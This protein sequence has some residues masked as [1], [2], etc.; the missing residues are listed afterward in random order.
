MSTAATAMPLT[1]DTAATRRLHRKEPVPW[2]AGP[3]GHS[4]VGG[5][6]RQAKHPDDPAAILR[7]CEAPQNQQNTGAAAAENAELAL[8]QLQLSQKSLLGFVLVETPGVFNFPFLVQF[9]CFFLFNLVR[10]NVSGD[11]CSFP[12][13]FRFVLFILFILF[14]LFMLYAPRGIAIN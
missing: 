1:K 9:L 5:P 13:D 4:Q 6:T 8:L 7:R 14:I 11:F 12:T 3:H 10:F 2:L